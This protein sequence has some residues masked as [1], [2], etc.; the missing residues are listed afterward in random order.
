MLTLTCHLQLNHLFYKNAYYRFTRLQQHT[1]GFCRLWVLLYSQRHIRHRYSQLPVVT[2]IC[3]IWLEQILIPAA[4]VA[5]SPIY[6][7]TAVRV[8]VF[9]R[10][11]AHVGACHVPALCGMCLL[12]CLSMSIRCVYTPGMCCSTSIWTSRDRPAYLNYYMLLVSCNT[13]KNLLNAK[14]TQSDVNRNKIN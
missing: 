9:R 7:R 1:S 6:M 8:V 10:A 3:R 4:A 13:L 2:H 12:V 5:P 14:L 11:T